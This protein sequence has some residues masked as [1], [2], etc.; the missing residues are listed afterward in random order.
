[1]VFYTRYGYFEYSMMFFGLSKPLASIQRYIN[2]I[3]TEKLNTFIVVY[4]DNIL[5]DM[6][7]PGEP[8][9]KAIQ[10]VLR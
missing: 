9:I 8:Y 4:L 2:K 1:M 7:D 3:L 6:K 10:S 5:I